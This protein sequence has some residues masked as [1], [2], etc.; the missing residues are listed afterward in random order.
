MSR[1]L[2]VLVVSPLAD[3]YTWYLD[4]PFR[5]RTDVGA[6]K[7]IVVPSRFE[8]DFASVPSP[9]WAIFPKWGTYGSAAI[10]H[11]W[12][13]WHQELRRDQADAVFL[14]AMTDSRV[15]PWKRRILYHAVRW[16]GGAAWRE[17]A[18]LRAKGVTRMQ[19]AREPRAGPRRPSWKRWTVLPRRRWA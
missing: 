7:T 14:E 1:F 12:L 11:D 6:T 2:D 9:L 17:N 19:P 13:Y 3:G 16:F 15:K 8:T 5:Y 10:V 4:R 18:S